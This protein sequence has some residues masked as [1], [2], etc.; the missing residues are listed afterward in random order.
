M[1]NPL[2]ADVFTVWDIILIRFTNETTAQYCLSFWNLTRRLLQSKLLLSNQSSRFKQ[3]LQRLKLHNIINTRTNFTNPE[4]TCIDL[5]IS[6]DPVL[7]RNTY[8]SPPFCSTNSVI[9]LDLQF[10]SHKHYAYRREIVDYNNA[11]SNNSI[12]S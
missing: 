10:C 9:G 3:I 7:V 4:G 8:V 5:L 6:S 12:V 1:C 2:T 11:D